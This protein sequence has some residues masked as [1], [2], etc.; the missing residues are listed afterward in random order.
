MGNVLERVV[1]PAN[2]PSGTN[3]L[4]TGTAAHTYTV[5]SMVIVNDSAGSI[6][7]KLGVN[8]VADANLIL[9]AV[10]LLAGEFACWDGFL[11]L[12][13]TET[14]QANATAS[15]LTFSASGMDQS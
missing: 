13:G 3:T 6:T 7:V 2:I 4:F 5:R 14:I 9:P 8:G 11:A 10:A 15:G 1:G 12:S